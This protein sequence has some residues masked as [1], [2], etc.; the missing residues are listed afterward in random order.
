MPNPSSKL[1]TL[2]R[3]LAKRL[4]HN[5]MARLGIANTMR[6]AHTYN[7]LKFHRQDHWRRTLYREQLPELLAENGAPTPPTLKM[8]DGGAIDTSM[9]LPHLDRALEDSEKIIAERAGLRVPSTGAYRSYFQDVWT[10]EDA[11]KS[12]AF[13]D[14]ASSSDVLATVGQYLQCLPALSPPLPAGVRFVESN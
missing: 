8:H 4:H 11:A 6:L 10:P 14:F 12:P 9:S 3:P 1:D 7:R 2:V 5:H 13:L